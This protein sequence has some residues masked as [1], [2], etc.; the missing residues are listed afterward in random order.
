M[1]QSNPRGEICL[2]ASVTWSRSKGRA[3]VIE[4]ATGHG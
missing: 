2:V 4:Y 3:N 1:I